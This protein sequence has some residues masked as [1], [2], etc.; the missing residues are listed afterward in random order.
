KT[1]CPTSGAT[2]T[3]PTSSSSPKSAPRAVPRRSVSS[4]VITPSSRRFLRR[5]TEPVPLA[6]PDFP[7]NSLVPFRE[8]AGSHPDGVVDL[9]IGSPVDPVP[10]LIR[11]ALA[12]AVDAPGYPATQGSPEVR[13]AIVGWYA[14]RG[15]EIGV[16][17]AI[18]TIGS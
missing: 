7:W 18:P 4:R 1:T 12:A 8:A 3:R 15:V 14:R 5:A 2:T 13:S 6:L 17:N 16:E 10:A 9:A 11:D